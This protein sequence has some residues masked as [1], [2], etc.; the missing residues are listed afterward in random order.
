MVMD[1][2]AIRGEIQDGDILLFRGKSWL[3][4]LICWITRSPYSHSAILGWWNG[5]LMVLEAVP[6]GVVASRMSRV[7]NKY[8]GQ[9]E[10]WTT[11]EKLARFEVI[12]TAQLLLGKHRSAFKL[13]GQ[14]K[15]RL[16]GRRRSVRPA[17]E[18]PEPLSEDFVSSEFVRRV[19]RAGGVE[20]ATHSPDL[21]TT[22]GDIARSPSVRKV[23]ALV[24]SQPGKIAPKVP[25]ASPGARLGAAW[26]APLQPQ[27]RNRRSS[28]DGAATRPGAGESRRLRSVPRMSGRVVEPFGRFDSGRVDPRD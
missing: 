5:H 3:S 6:T 28:G 18:A 26:V 10:L 14:L 11:D 9:I 4:R 19:W 16:L 7:V 25:G 20:L 8:S 15:Q 12:Q 27:D 1:Y 21:P 13:L 2:S 24:C 22:P 23:G 17:L